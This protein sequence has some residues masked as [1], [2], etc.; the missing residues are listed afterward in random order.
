MI[1]KNIQVTVAGVKLSVPVLADPET[2]LR[3]AREVTRRIRLI[4]RESA[5]IDTQAFALQAAISLAEDLEARDQV[6]ESDDAEM[7]LALEKLTEALRSLL[8]DFPPA[9]A[10]ASEP[11]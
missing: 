1:S 5:R 10:D 8:E 7:V 4:E 9:K 11:G 3:A 6:Q 2:T